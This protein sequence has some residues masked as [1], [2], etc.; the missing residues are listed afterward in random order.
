MY[1]TR[2][3]NRGFLGLLFVLMTGFVLATGP[4]SVA[5]ANEDDA[6]GAKNVNGER[7]YSL[8]EMLNYAIEDEYKARAE[9]ELIISEMDGGRP[10]TNIVAAE[11]KHISLLEPLFEKYEIDI[12]EDRASGHTVLP[13]SIQSALETGVKAEVENIAMYEKF[14]SQDLPSY[15]E[16]VFLRLKK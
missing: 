9:Y 15:I 5:V 10:F 6:Y 1:R 3:F 8:E 16:E 7:T 11:K 14:L 13:E 4:L 12:P 2:K